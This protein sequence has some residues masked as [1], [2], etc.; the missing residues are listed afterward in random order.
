MKSEKIAAFSLIELSIVILV[1]GLLISGIIQGSKIASKAT[2]NSARAL[3]ESSPVSSI[4]S[5]SLWLESTSKASFMDSESDDNLLISKWYSINPNTI[6]KVSANQTNNSLKPKYISNAINNLP[7]IQLDGLDDYLE[8]S[9]YS[10]DANITNNFSVFVVAQATVT[11]QIDSEAMSGITGN[12]GQKFLIFPTL[13]GG[14]IMAGAGISMGTNGISF[15][16]H[17]GGYMPAILVYQATLTKPLVLLMEYN[18][19]NPN[20]Y[21]NGTLVRTSPYTSTKTV[22]SPRVI[23]GPYYGAFSG[24]VGEVIIFSEV[25]KKSDKDYITDYLKKKWGVN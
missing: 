4:R 12:S 24:Y 25:L 7:A 11:H 14:G 8:T 3:T 16:E 22:F 6:K 18:N 1:I 9:S 23:G 2:L 17:M 20:L 15:Y 19:K 13:M 5:L 21:I 10:E